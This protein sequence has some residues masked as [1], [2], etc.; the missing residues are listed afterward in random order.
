MNYL[1]IDA[2]ASATKWSL[3]SRAGLVDS[4]TLPAMDGH[5][6]RQS[7]LARMHEVL[8]HIS[9]SIQAHEVTN[10]YMGITGINHDGKIQALLKEKFGCESRVVSD[11][12]LAFHANF[13]TGTGIL[14]YAGTG[15]IAFAI[16]SNGI[17]HQIGGWGYLLGDEGAGYW[18]GREALRHTLFALESKDSI[19]EFPLAQSI[20]NEIQADDWDGIKAFVYSQERSQIAALSKIVDKLASDGD[21][22]SIEIMRKAA[23]YLADLVQRTDKSLGTSQ[24]PV[25]F[26]GGIS[27]SKLIGEELEKIF[28]KRFKVSAV[29]ISLRAAELSRK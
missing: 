19:Q 14:L 2:G 11:I 18:L 22:S 10:I 13:E 15:S 26:T 1:G 21:K 25:T 28:E 7:S 27:Q 4:G 20:L 16:D 12:E 6:N 29:D 24:Y 23:G 3:V 17:K 9:T 5:L 8:D